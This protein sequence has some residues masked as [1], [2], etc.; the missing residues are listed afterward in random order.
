MYDVSLM[1]RRPRSTH[2]QQDSQK[3]RIA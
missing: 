1:E 2:A 3:R